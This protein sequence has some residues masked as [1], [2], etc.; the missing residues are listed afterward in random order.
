MSDQSQKLLSSASVL[1]L[2]LLGAAGVEADIDV[3]GPTF[4]GA[5]SNDSSQENGD[6]LAAVSAF[7]A[8]VITFA[9]TSSGGDPLA[10]AGTE[11]DI[12]GTSFD[13]GVVFQSPDTE[14]VSLTGTTRTPPPDNYRIGPLPGYSGPLE[15][16]FEGLGL[17]G[18]VRGV[19]IGALGLQKD[20]TVTLYDSQ[21]DE[22]L[23]YTWPETVNSAFFIGFVP[24]E[25]SKTIGRVVIDGSF[26]TVQDIEYYVPEPAAAL[27]QLATLA[28]LAGLAAGRRRPAQSPR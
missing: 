24:Q 22:I 26:Y 20:D 1:L 18:A 9:E 23:A 12:D 14:L 27:L 8:T 11:V 17:V 5:Y 10:G 13:T 15:I 19:G 21:D 7:D 3:Y 25:P 28:S 16:T 2:F 6:F 4:V